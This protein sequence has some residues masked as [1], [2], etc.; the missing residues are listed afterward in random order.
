MLVARRTGGRVAS[1][2]N[3]IL[4][5]FAREIA[6]S[7]ALEELE[8]EASEAEHLAAAGDL[9]TAI[10]SAVSHDLR[11]PLSGIKASVTSLLQEDVSWTPAEAREFLD[12]I[13]EESDR[14]NA[15]VGNL[16]DMSRL[17]TGCARRQPRRRSGSTR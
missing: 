13:D 8:A 5:A 12:T 2:D 3:R 17:Q 6:A 10:L 16:L 7:L 4:E 15:L 14:L 9:R 1:A 11:T